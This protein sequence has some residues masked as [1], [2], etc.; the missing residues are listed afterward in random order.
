[1]SKYLFRRLLQ[2]VPV[3]IGVALI[4][5]VL[6]QLSGNPVRSLLA[7]GTNPETIR[8]VNEFYGFNKPWYERFGKYMGNLATGNLGASILNHGEPVREMIVNGMRVTLKLALGAVIFATIMGIALGILSAWKP[9]SLVDYASSV[10]AAIGVS[11][12]AFFLAMLLMM[13]F[14]IH[15]KWF[16]VGDYRPGEIKYLVLPCLT[17]GLISTA[18]I[19]RLT[20]N[21]MLETLSQDFIRSG[22]AKGLKKWTVLLGHALPNA[23]VPVITIIG[24]DFASLLVG[25]VL[26]ETVFNIPG[27]GQVISAA[28]FGRDLPVVM[29]CCI[30]FAL[31]FILINLVVDVSYAFLDPRIRHAD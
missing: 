28:I 19:A 30:V 12:P 18:S 8:R 24:T 2:S 1:M 3:I 31:V 20:R 5:F 14:A 23:L 15:Y 16:P 9:Y 27:M 21:C 4:A 10:F 22:R 17:L 29:G 11:F 13:V 26:T 6:T 7:Q 25:A